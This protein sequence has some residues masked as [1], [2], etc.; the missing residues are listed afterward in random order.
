MASDAMTSCHDIDLSDLSPLTQL[1]E[2]VIGERCSISLNTPPG[3]DVLLPQLKKI[4]TGV[5]L[6]TFSSVSLLQC[7]RP[8]L[9]ELNLY[10]YHMKTPSSPGLNWNK[11]PKFWTKLEKLSIRCIS[12]SL[13]VEKVREMALGLKN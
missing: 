6:D 11:I 1:E 4:T 13:T 2:L 9:I 5:C 3:T 7:E 10:C 12:Q 8:E